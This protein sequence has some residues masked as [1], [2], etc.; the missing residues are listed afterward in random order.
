MAQDLMEFMRELE[1]SEPEAFIAPQIRYGSAEDL[2]LVYFRPDE[3]YAK[4]LNDHV[5]VFISLNGNDLVGCQIQGLKHHLQSDGHFSLAIKTGSK[6]E[7]GI[8]FHLLAYDVPEAESRSRLVELGQKAK[9]IEFDST[10]MA[11]A[12]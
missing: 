1:A 5:T 2:L 10:T 8:Y 3:S 7:L 9:G 11:W 12:S 4:Q 6:I